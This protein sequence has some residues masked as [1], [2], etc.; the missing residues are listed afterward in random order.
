V[1]VGERFE[2]TFNP[3]QFYRQM[4]HK[5]DPGN[6]RRDEALHH[7]FLDAFGRQFG[8]A[9]RHIGG[10]LAQI[11]CA[12]TGIRRIGLILAITG[13]AHRPGHIRLSGEKCRQTR[14]ARNR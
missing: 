9:F 8:D 6:Y 12:Q 1:T 7:H 14:I 13:G 4:P 11:G 3:F 2:M 10:R 5:R